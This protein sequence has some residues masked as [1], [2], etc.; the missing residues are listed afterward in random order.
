MPRKGSINLGIMG[1][2]IQGT[3]FLMPPEEVI[4]S[5]KYSINAGIIPVLPAGNY[6]PLPGTMNPL[7]KVKE[8]IVV[9]GATNDGLELCSF[10]SRGI[11]GVN[12]SG[13]TVVC[14]CQDLIGRTHSGI[15]PSIEEHKNKE[16]LFTKDR[17]EKQVCRK[18][19]DAEWEVIKEKF[20]IGTG[21]SQAVEYLVDIISYIAEFRKNRGLISDIKS[22]RSILTYIAMPMPKYQN[23]E[24]GAGFINYEIVNRY[25]RKVE[26]GS[27]KSHEKI[28]WSKEKYFNPD[29]TKGEIVI[30]WLDNINGEHHFNTTNE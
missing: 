14:P 4:S 24:V 13:P 8:S 28:F 10:S 6:G 22:I 27:I 16:H 1:V 12:Y 30:F 20:I 19:S 25:L 5:L 11:P 2:P 26:N 23:Y 18:I 21:T 15:I 29:A 17:L 9:G 7:S 3:P